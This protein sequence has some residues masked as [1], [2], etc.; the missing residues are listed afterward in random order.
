M[1]DGSTRENTVAHPP[2]TGDR[3]LTD[4]DISTLTAL[5]TPVVR[6]ALG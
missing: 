2:G 1:K 5:L 4:A 3:L 6:P